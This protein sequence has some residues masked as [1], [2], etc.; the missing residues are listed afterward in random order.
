MPL[1]ENI[2]YFPDILA[3][4][5]LDEND[6]TPVQGIAVMLTLFARKKNDYHM[7][8]QLSDAQGWIQIRREWVERQVEIDRNLFIMDYASSVEECSE[9]V[10]LRVMSEDEIRRAISAMQTYRGVLGNSIVGP[11][12]LENASNSQFQSQRVVVNL[13]RP[14]ENVKKV[15]IKLKRRASR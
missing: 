14:E 4:R 5:I 12:D 11:I 8:P 6:E 3:V 7:I 1:A 13:N 15:F 2:L 9:G 10:E